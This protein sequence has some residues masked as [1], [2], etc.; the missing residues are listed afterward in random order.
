MLVD[1]RQRYDAFRSDLAQ[2]DLNVEIRPDVS[3]GGQVW[4]LGLMWFIG[5]LSV[6]IRFGCSVW[7]N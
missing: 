2:G 1:Q 4:K 5:D 3:Y 7:E 6:E